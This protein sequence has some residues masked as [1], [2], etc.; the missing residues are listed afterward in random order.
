MTLIFSLKVMYFKYIL[1]HVKGK[2]HVTSN[3]KM[4]C[5]TPNYR[6][7]KWHQVPVHINDRYLPWP[8]RI[9]SHHVE[10]LE[11]YSKLS[12]K[13]WKVQYCESLNSPCFI[14]ELSFFLYS[15]LCLL[16]ASFRSFTNKHFMDAGF[17][18]TEVSR[19]LQIQYWNE[20]KNFWR[21]GGFDSFIWSGVFQL[22][23]F[24]YTYQYINCPSCIKL[25]IMVYLH[26]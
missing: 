8:G 25:N 9:W 21:G 26:C 12:R 11:E 22:I 2:E 16:H 13:K 1:M 6:F 7:H 18:M 4:E 20:R 5:T 3:R 14:F 19:G 17:L 15:K 23:H 10:S 24:G